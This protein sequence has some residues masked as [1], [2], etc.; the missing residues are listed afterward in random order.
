MAHRGRNISRIFSGA[1]RTAAERVAGIGSQR[2]RQ[3]QN[4]APDPKNPYNTTR[5]LPNRMQSA[6][7]QA[8]RKQV[9]RE[10]QAIQK[11]LND[12]GE[13]D[14]PRDRLPK[15]Q[16]EL[17]DLRMLFFQALQEGKI[18]NFKEFH[19]YLKN[20]LI[21]THKNPKMAEQATKAYWKFMRTFS[22]T[23]REKLGIRFKK[24]AEIAVHGDPGD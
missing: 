19:N 2:Q 7:Q 24:L 8:T 20:W 15:E 22:R 9:M 16:K 12:R 11:I 13:M 6:A 23:Q 5:N 10:L 3:Q 4:Q 14:K 1:A 21:E 17:Y 18:R